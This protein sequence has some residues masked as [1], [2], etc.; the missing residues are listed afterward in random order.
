[1][2]NNGRKE[3]LDETGLEHIRNRK[4]FDNNGEDDKSS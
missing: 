4:T 1:M 3:K 2:K